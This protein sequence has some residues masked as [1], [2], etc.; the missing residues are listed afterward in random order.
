MT[1]PPDVIQALKAFL[2]QAIYQ[3]S[4][5]KAIA[6]DVLEERIRFDSQSF[7]V[8]DGTG[9]YFEYQYNLTGFEM[10]LRDAPG[11]VYTVQGACTTYHGPDAITYSK[12]FNLSTG[13]LVP[14]EQEIYNY[15]GGTEWGEQIMLDRENNTAPWARY[16]TLFT[17]Q[18]HDEREQSG[19]SKFMI[20]PH[21]AWRLSNMPNPNRDPWY[22]TEANP[23]HLNITDPG[24]AFYYPPYRVK[25]ARP[26]LQ[27]TQNDTYTYK[28]HIVNHVT[29]LKDLPGLKLSPFIMN[30]LF[31]LEFGEPVFSKLLDNLHFGALASNAFFDPVQRMLD[32]TRVSLQDDFKGLVH[33]SF[34]YSREVVRN[35][36]L[37]YPSLQRS[38]DTTLNNSARDGGPTKNADFF[39]ESSEVAA[40]SVY[41]LIVTPS[42]CAFLW[43]LLLGWNTCFNPAPTLDSNSAK[44]RRGLRLYSFKAVH[45][46][47]YLDEALSQQ[48]RWSGRNTD[49]P[50]IR[51]LDADTTTPSV[52]DG[53]ASTLSV[54]TG[55]PLVHSRSPY[56]KPKVVL[57]EGPPEPPRFRAVVWRKLISWFPGSH[58]N[59]GIKKQQYDVAMTTVSD[60]MIPLTNVNQKT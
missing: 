19:V 49:T 18:Y 5:R 10:G 16:I 9:A 20:I 17:Q 31:V 3:A 34:V 41:A 40:I 1:V 50:Y 51:D 59:Q 6:H 38:K 14:E 12:T 27:C 11:L 23:T 22:E 36:V 32:T 33:M 55:T 28:E 52:L 21:T 4:A 26:P 58:H 54:D 60:P 30:N 13:Y 42:V 46:F 56:P 48:R 39:L 29:K 8:V 53:G 7:E 35:T 57:V 44:A 43:L 45:L 47:R 2:P 25:R 37:L 15:S 24:L